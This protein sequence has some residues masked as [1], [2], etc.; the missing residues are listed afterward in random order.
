M[1]GNLTDTDLPPEKII[2]GNKPSTTIVYQKLSPDT[3]GMLIA[4]YEHR[5]FVQAAIWGINPFD[6]WGV[7]LGKTITR[8]IKRAIDAE[9]GDQEFDSSTQQ[10]IR[11]FHGRE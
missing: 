6:Q 2:P 9:N 10:L 8:D 7:E 5:T 4:L 3:L 1:R 11:R